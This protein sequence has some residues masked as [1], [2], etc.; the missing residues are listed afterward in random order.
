MTKE[1]DVTSDDDLA[2]IECAIVD[3]EDYR[4]D[5]D[6]ILG[7]GGCDGLDAP[8]GDHQADLARAKAY[9]EAWERIKLALDAP[10]DVKTRADAWTISIMD[11]FED[12]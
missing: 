10:A 1:Y 12:V 11:Q 4:D 6:E 8:C 2:I 9:R 5:P 3:A 7:C